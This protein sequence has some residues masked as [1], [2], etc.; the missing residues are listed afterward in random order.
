[1]RDLIDLD[2]R[3]V[4]MRCGRPGTVSA[5]AAEHLRPGV[6]GAGHVNEILT[7]AISFLRRIGEDAVIVTRTSR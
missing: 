7:P 5:G 1:V 3:E 4:V 6:G 2:R